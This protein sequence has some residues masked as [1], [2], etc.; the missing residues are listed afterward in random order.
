MRYVDAAAFDEYN[1][2]DGQELV[3]SVLV[4]ATVGEAFDTLLKRSWVGKNK[5]LAPG[6]GRGLVGH[7]RQLSTG[8]IETIQSS[9]L[10]QGDDAIASICYKLQVDQSWITQDHIGL[11][12]F[13]PDTTTGKATTDKT[14]VMWAIKIVP[15]SFGSVFLCGGSLLR[16][17]QRAAL[18]SVLDGLKNKLS[19][20]KHQ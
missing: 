5:E 16:V 11:I 13:V 18:T 15:T 12:S 8:A 10:P 19:K 9:G 17:V 3:V 7:S 14:L 6:V 1:A 20:Q 4:D 2:N